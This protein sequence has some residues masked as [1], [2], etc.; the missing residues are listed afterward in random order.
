[1]RQEVTALQGQLPAQSS[2]L[3]LLSRQALVSLHPPQR[4]TP[5][6]CRFSFSVSPTSNSASRLPPPII[7]MDISLR[8]SLHAARRRHAPVPLVL[9][10]VLHRQHSFAFPSSFPVLSVAALG[11]L[12][13]RAARAPQPCD[14]ASFAQRFEDCPTCL[15]RFCWLRDATAQ[16]VC[17]EPSLPLSARRDILFT[18]EFNRTSALLREAAA[19]HKCT[20]YFPAPP[21]LSLLVLLWCPLHSVAWP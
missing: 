7:W 12:A 21:S 16:H 2:R 5:Q 6:A 13:A 15:L 3:C 18:S 10:S 19:L 17:A 20:L 14:A 8:I 1:M 9:A 11:P 4:W